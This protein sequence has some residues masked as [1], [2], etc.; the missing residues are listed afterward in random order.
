MSHRLLCLRGASPHWGTR[1]TSSTPFSPDGAAGWMGSIHPRGSAAGCSRV[2]RGACAQHLIVAE[3]RHHLDQS[4]RDEGCGLWRKPP[5]GQ[6][7]Q[8][9]QTKTK[10]KTQYA[11]RA[12]LST[13]KRWRERALVKLSV[14]LNCFHLCRSQGY[15]WMPKLT[16]LSISPFWFKII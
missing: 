1:S 7:D 16:E 4:H 2:L 6:R 14:T 12:G 5:C 9:T 13:A 3:Q 15:S 8:K 10:Q 11:K